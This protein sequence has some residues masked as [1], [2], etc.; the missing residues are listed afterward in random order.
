MPLQVPGQPPVYH[1]GER[2]PQAVNARRVIP[3]QST[4]L[5]P[6]STSPAPSEPVPNP[7]PTPQSE[8]DGNNHG[9]KVWRKKQAR[10]ERERL[11]AQANEGQNAGE[12]DILK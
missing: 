9:D 6:K 8:A 4:E 3:S 11:A 5:L 1:E 7:N 2:V 10:L 12:A